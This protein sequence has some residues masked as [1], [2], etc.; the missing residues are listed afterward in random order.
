MKNIFHF[1]CG[2][3]HISAVCVLG[4]KNV[5]F[6]DVDLDYMHDCCIMTCPCGGRNVRSGVRSCP[7]QTP[8]MVG[9]SGQ[10]AFIHPELETGA[11]LDYITL[12]S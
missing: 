12:T 4:R 8:T 6:L 7:G 10:P 1:F 5:S 2:E 11:D 9:G 3:S